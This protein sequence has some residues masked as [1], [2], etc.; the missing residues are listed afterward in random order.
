MSNQNP[1]FCVSCKRIAVMGDCIEEKSI[2][3][4]AVSIYEP[5]TNLVT[6]VWKVSSANV[7]DHIY[8]QILTG[9]GKEFKIMGTSW[10]A[11][12]KYTIYEAIEPV[13]TYVETP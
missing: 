11:D 8:K 6:Y 5:D 1:K 2:P 4:F 12:N 13:F 10:S 9:I 7:A 3:Q